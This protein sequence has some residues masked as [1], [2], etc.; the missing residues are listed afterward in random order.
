MKEVF[1]TIHIWPHVTTSTTV[2]YTWPL[3]TPSTQPN[4]PGGVDDLDYDSREVKYMR[5]ATT[6]S[7]TQVSTPRSSCS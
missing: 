5:P 6:L 2:I 4:K 3:V 1:K 7:L